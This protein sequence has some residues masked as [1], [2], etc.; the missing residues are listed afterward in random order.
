MSSS[1]RASSFWSC[2]RAFSRASIFASTC[3]AV[4][5]VG[6]HRLLVVEL[7]LL[8]VGL[9][10]DQLRLGS[11]RRSSRAR[12]SD[13]RSQLERLRDARP[14]PPLAL[15][16][17]ARP[18]RGGARARRPRATASRTTASQA[19]LEGRTLACRRLRPREIR[20]L[21]A[22]ARRRPGPRPSSEPPD[23]AD[24]A[25]GAVAGAGD[26]ARRPRHRR[27]AGQQERRGD[28]ERPAQGCGAARR[29]PPAGSPPS[30][31]PRPPA[32]PPACAA[33]APRARRRR[34]RASRSATP[35]AR[36]C[37]PGSPKV[38]R[39]RLGL[40]RGRRGEREELRVAQMAF[41]PV[42]GPWLVLYAR[43]SESR[44][45]IFWAARNRCD[46]IVP[47]SRP[48]DLGDLRD[49]HLLEV[50]HHEDRPLPG[51]ERADAPA[52]AARGSR[53]RPPGARARDRR[54]RRELLRAPPLVLVLAA[55]RL[56]EVQHEA[57]PL[58]P[59]LAP[60]DADPRQPGLERRALPEVVEA[61]VRAQ[62]ALLR[63]AVGFPR[64]AQESVGDPRDLSSGTGGRSTRRAPSARPG[65][66]G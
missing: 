46:L 55:G 54:L 40:S 60:V 15:R 35:G 30:S 19:L 5:L 63:R 28:A 38:P 18:G 2:A 3:L 64:V 29:A 61:L 27:A 9:Q 44:S 21:A 41:G 17:P 42:S 25:A 58:Q 20:G 10:V 23:A 62:E 49:R 56:M 11:A 53:V 45:R 8:E 7:L 39:Q 66:P 52:G 51:R 36:G 14:L 33:R 24:A 22:A 50:L 26:E 13:R 1:I 65:S 47:A 59:V 4:D 12:A 37:R 43:K 31:R 32:T 16:A 34:A 48:V 57:A 6:S